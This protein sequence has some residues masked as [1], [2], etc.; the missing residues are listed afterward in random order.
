[1][2]VLIVGGYGTF[3]ARLARML[4]PDARLSLVIAGRSLAKA[5]GLCASLKAAGSCTALTFDRTGDVRDALVRVRP[6]VLVDAAG[7][8]QLYGDDPYR[9]VRACIEAGVSYLDLADSADFVAGIERFDAQARERNVFVLSGLSTFPALSSAVVQALAADLDRIDAVRA[10]VAPSPW[11]GVGLN[12]IRAISSYAG[13]PLS[14]LRDG[15]RVEA[16]AIIDDL[17]R[18]VAVPGRVP[19]HPTRFSLAETPDL[20]L[21]DRLWPGL[22]EVW[23]GAGPKPALLHRMLS[24]LAGLVRLRLLPSL[25]PLA[26]LFHWGARVFRWGEHRGGMFIEVDGLR[27]DRPVRRAWHLI[28]EGDDG[29]NIPSMGAA[30]LVAR[31][32]SGI[33]PRP[34]ARPATHE[35]SL[36]E[37]EGQFARFDIAS[38][39][40]EEEPADAPL[41][42][43]LLGPAW[44]R[45]PEPIR[46]LHDLEGEMTVRGEASVE[47][48]RN[49]LAWLIAAVIGFP[50]AAEHTPVE[51]RF[52]GKD[53]VETWRRT[54]GTK[55]FSSTQE[56]GRAGADR[57]IIERFGPVAVAMAVVVSETRLDLVIRR[58]TLFGLPMPLWLAPGGEAFETVEDGRFRFD[59]D[60]RAPL[61]G[62]VVRYR[63]WLVPV[64]Q[65]QEP[66]KAGMSST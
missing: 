12:V 55:S 62:R 19:M 37:Y 20:T 1:M 59:V 18:T 52:T 50:A 14:I 61:A 60:I 49:P 9:L 57:L 48:G 36:T 39:R 35:L 64:E 42:R 16:P 58:W 54:F 17:T 8:F 40:W 32:A 46:V 23:T 56:M 33:A 51:V 44:D 24:L 4:A 28:A 30:A 38:G 10:G 13:K 47:R 6:D 63:G 66:R 26:G 7:P 2:K 43:R 15:R 3:G 27:D 22:A 34:G 21:A 41:Y 25:Q 53:S 5:Q 11:A 45:L 65:D 29:P 31:V